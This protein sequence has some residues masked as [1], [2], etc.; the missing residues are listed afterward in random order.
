MTSFPKGNMS[1][2]RVGTLRILDF[3]Q[4]IKN[5]RIF[6]ESTKQQQQ[7]RVVSFWLSSHPM[8]CYIIEVFSLTFEQLQQCICIFYNMMMSTA[9][10]KNSAFPQLFCETLREQMEIL[11]PSQQSVCRLLSKHQLALSPS[12]DPT[13]LNQVRVA[14]TEALIK[15]QPE[16]F[17]SF[18]LR[19]FLLSPLYLSS[20]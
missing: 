13:M 1:T 5:C 10:T 14:V 2:L 19:T 11:L 16:T 3:S 6:R 8:R 18:H 12:L 20:Q 9:W 15:N 4:F 7:K 17:E